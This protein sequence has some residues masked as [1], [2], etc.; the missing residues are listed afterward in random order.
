MRSS[1]IFELEGNSGM[2]AVEGANPK[3]LFNAR[4]WNFIEPVG[5]YGIAL[6]VMWTSMFK[7][8]WYIIVLGV[9]VLWLLVLS[10]IAHYHYERD[11][12]L[13]PEQQNLGF[14]CAECRGLGS[15]GRYFK[16][17]PE[18][19]EPPLV[20]KHYRAIIILLALF[21][22]QFSFALV[23]FWNYPEFDEIIAAIGLPVTNDSKLLIGVILVPVLLVALFFCFSFLVRFDTLI[24]GAK[25]SLI[26]IAMGIPLVL[27]FTWLFTLIP[28]LPFFPSG[29]PPFV[30]RYAIGIPLI[31]LFAVLFTG[32]SLVTW[33]DSKAFKKPAQFVLIMLGIGIP[34]GFLYAWVFLI[35]PALPD[36]PDALPANYLIQIGTRL[37]DFTILEF[38][39]Q[40]T[41]YIWWGYIQQML[42]LSLFNTMF[43]RA[44]NV[45]NRAP[46]L[47]AGIWTGFL[48]GLIHLPTFWLSFFTWVAGVFWASFFMRSKNLFVMGVVH[49]ALGSLL[50]ELTPVKFSVG[51]ASV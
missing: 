33:R 16:G 2:L 28:A 9:L 43:T 46:Q 4:L 34:L 24:K 8:T 5:L 38:M 19:K 47:L 32:F 18:N 48:F 37:G 36:Y 25:Q 3:K 49:G 6:V 7:G 40:Y 23:A 31:A 29:S 1:T 50:N 26:V 14:Y 11:L 15:P 22:I 21:G 17:N 27:G 20:K 35:S 30:A 39:G 44:F 45:K 51:P 12:F 41:G 13:K 10:P 42:F